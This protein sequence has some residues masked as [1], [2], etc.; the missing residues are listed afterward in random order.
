[1]LIGAGYVASDQIPSVML[2]EWDHR[3]LAPAQQMCVDS[4]CE[5]YC[6][7]GIMRRSRRCGWALPS[8]NQKGGGVLDISW[9]CDG[10]VGVVPQP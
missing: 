7:A 1:M 8:A 2:Q 6:V 3:H 10:A 4:S 5:A 9:S